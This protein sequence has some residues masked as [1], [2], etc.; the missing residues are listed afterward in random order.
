MLNPLA[1]NI[2]KTYVAD[3][4][5]DVYYY[6][7]TFNKLTTI[8]ISSIRVMPDNRPLYKTRT[9][10]LNEAIIKLIQDSEQPCTTSA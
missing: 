3:S 7:V 2:Y 9:K 4:P 10:E 1:D 6:K 8:V 5:V